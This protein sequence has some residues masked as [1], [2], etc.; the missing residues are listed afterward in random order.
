M[1]GRRSEVPPRAPYTYRKYYIRIFSELE[2]IF[3]SD[4]SLVKINIVLTGLRAGTGR[5]S[6]VY[7]SER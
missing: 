5:I 7:G 6:T 2:G 4:V 3:L 1:S